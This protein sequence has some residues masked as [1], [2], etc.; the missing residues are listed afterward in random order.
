MAKKILTQT[1]GEEIANS[2]SHG[3]SSLL[4]IAG[5]VILIVKAAMNAG[6]IEVVSVSLYGASLILLYSFSTLY[7]AITHKTA[8]KVLRIFDHCSIFLLILGSYI[9]VCLCVIR[10]AMGWTLF[11]INAFCAVLGIVLNAINI[12]RWKKLSMVLYVLMGWSVLMSIG[13][14][15]S[16][17]QVPG[18]ILL[19]LG[20]IMYTLGIIF[21][22]NKKIKYMHFVWHLFV[23]AGSVL[24]YFFVLF[25]CI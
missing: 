25:Y 9:P 19:A 16:R 11:G 10:G 20:G 2:V 5:T 7:H 23:F 3:C 21:Y 12:E 22:K 17:V 15:I 24:Q 1:L 13:T 18:M 14:V 6:A 8:K 4:A